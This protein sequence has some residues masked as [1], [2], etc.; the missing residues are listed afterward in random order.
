[1]DYI[2]GME[3]GLVCISHISVTVPVSEFVFNMFGRD[4]WGLSIS[5]GLLHSLLPFCSSCLTHMHPQMKGGFLIHSVGWS[6]ASKRRCFIPDVVSGFQLIFP[7]NA[8]YW[9]FV[10]FGFHSKW[11]LIADCLG[12]PSCRQASCL[13]WMLFSC[14]SL[15]VSGFCPISVRLRLDI[16]CGKEPPR[17]LTFVGLK[18][19]GTHFTMRWR[20]L[21]E[22]L[23][24][25]LQT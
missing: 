9:V 5:M 1:M 12:D 16:T 7:S 22:H 4:R 2:C 6:F 8:Y 14:E 18:E 13:S 24:L 10:W 21:R 20:L 19:R 25:E 3:A 17:G 11:W 15:I 23:R